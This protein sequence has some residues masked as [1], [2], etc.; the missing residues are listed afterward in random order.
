MTA[1]TTRAQGFT[2]IEVVGAFFLTIVILV[3]V[4]GV[5]VENG[6]QRAA[7]TA[8][9]EERLAAASAMDLLSADFAGSIFL[10]R[11]EAD[12]PD[13]YPWR[14]IG[15][16]SG[17]LG[18]TSVRFVTQA[19]PRENP[20]TGSSAWNEVAWFLSTD[21]DGVQVLH[22]W[23]SP[24]PPSD[25]VREWPR[26]DDPGASRVAVGVAAFG[27]RFLDVEGN[28]VD[29]WDS[30]FAPPE[31]AMP[32]AV[33]VSLQMMRRVRAGDVP[34]DPEAIEMP[35]LLQS[36]RVALVMRPLDVAALIALGE[37][38]EETADCYT[39][40][41]CLAAGDSTWFQDLLAENCGGDDRLCETLRDSANTCWSTIQTTYPA[42]A[43]R[44]PEACSA[45]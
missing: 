17:E 19:G 8:L 38:Q 45:S 15:A 41:Q 42:I 23:R 32:E 31:Q 30:T 36:R 21:E 10:L 20:T 16:G 39:V 29:E 4:T 3:F 33:E 5:F 9:M 1:G 18:S 40:D 11:A 34:D 27:V 13:A 26:P 28:W 14:F 37:D 35:G 25:A 12:D 22:R 24:R 44:A 6:R 7:A 43:A 2:L